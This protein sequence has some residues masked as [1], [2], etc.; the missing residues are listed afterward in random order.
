[1]KDLVTHNLSFWKA[2]LV[3]VTGTPLIGP[4][5]LAGFNG[6]WGRTSFQ[7]PTQPPDIFEV[8]SIKPSGPPPV[9]A[10][11][12]GGGVGPSG[13]C[14]GIA[15]I[16]PRRFV[17]TNA[18]LYRLIVVAYGFKNCAFSMDTGLITGGPEWIKSEPL[19]QP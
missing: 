8:A 14:S 4:M 9:A 15:Q 10:G 1:M 18:T 2:L 5:M 12:R 7:N 3:V 16:E 11:G 17:I 13:P 6:A 19:Q